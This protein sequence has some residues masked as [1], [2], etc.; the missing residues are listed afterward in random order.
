MPVYICLLEI[1]IALP[2]AESLKEKRRVVKSLAAHLRRRFG[3][4]VSEIADHDVRSRGVLLCAL[5]GGA[6]TQARA[7]E[8]ERF[9]EARCPDGCSV[10]RDLVTLKDIRA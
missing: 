1:R 6:D 3:A 8:V 4:A 10:G 5:V 2:H 9:V 7:D